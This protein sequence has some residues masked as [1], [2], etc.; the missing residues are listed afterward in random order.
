MYPMANQRHVDFHAFPLSFYFFYAFICLKP[1]LMAFS[2]DRAT[3]LIGKSR[4][5]WV[6]NQVVNE[7]LNGNKNTGGR[8]IDYLNWGRRVYTPV[9]G[10]V[11]VGSDGVHV[12]IFI[13]ATE[14]LSML[15]GHR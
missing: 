6:C 5:D 8:A 13:N 15:H 14:S 11:V 3:K 2:S 7:V 1:F 10:A 9:E 4:L 12:G